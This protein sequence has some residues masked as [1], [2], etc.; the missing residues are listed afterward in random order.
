MHGVVTAVWS[1]ADHN[2]AKDP[3]PSI[4]LIAGIGVEGDAHAG[5][6]VQHLSRVAK[7]PTQPNLRQIHLI[8][9]ELHD[10]LQMR[11]FSVVAGQMGENITTR[12][13]DLLGLPRGARLQIGAEAEIEVT[14]LRN[15]CH[16]LNKIE[17]GLMD[18]TLD[19]APEGGLIRKAGVMAIVLSGGQIRPDDTISVTLPKEPHRPLKPV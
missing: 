16:Q 1:A 17:P 8:H 9:G 2:M 4:Q 18:A 6:T 10:E 3:H 5:Q 14:G 19:R 12:N 13:I 11:G 15:P 7:D